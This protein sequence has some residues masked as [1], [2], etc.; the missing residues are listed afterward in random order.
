MNN[1]QP[2]LVYIEA[3]KTGVPSCRWC[4]EISLVNPSMWQPKEGR[5]GY[6]DFDQWPCWYKFVGK[7]T[8]VIFVSN[9]DF[10]RVEALEASADV[11]AGKVRRYLINLNDREMHWF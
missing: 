2:K 3:W 10:S 5:Y 6:Y 7:E 11:L 8:T 4:A 1:T 9:H